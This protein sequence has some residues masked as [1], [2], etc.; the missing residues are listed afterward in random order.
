M[1]CGAQTF[2]AETRRLF[3]STKPP[4][5]AIETIHIRP[6]N[7]TKHPELKD[8]RP[9]TT[10]RVMVSTAFIAYG[11]PPRESIDTYEQDCPVAN[12]LCCWIFDGQRDVARSRFGRIIHAVPREPL[13][14]SEIDQPAG[15]EW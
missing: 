6:S 4:A 3:G 2:L 1:I 5:D 8:A 15:V 12:V 9:T 13:R 7:Q 11:P 14:V 10:Q